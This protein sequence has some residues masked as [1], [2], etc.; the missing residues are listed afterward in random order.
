MDKDITIYDIAKGVGVSPTTVS[1][2]LNDHPAVNKKT[3]QRIYEIATQMGYRSN[4]FASN[5]RK[6]RTNTIGVIVPHLNSSFQSSVM[7]GMEKVATE[8]GYNL[9]ISQSMGTAEKEIANAKTMFNSRV[10]GLLV[11]LATDTENIDHFEPFFKKGVPVLFYDRVAEHKQS[12][13]I[14]IDNV[15]A[16][17]RATTHLIEQGCQRIVHITGNLRIN[18]YAHRLK[19]YKYALIDHDLPFN[20]SL[21]IVNDL[22]EEAGIEAAS[23]ILAMEPRPDGVFVSNDFCAANCMNALKQAGLS[24]PGDIAI[25]GFNNEPITRVV[26]P[27]LTTIDYPGYE[28]GEVAVRSLINYLDGLSDISITNTVTL[29]S[30]LI[31][32]G[33]SLRKPQV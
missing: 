26:E 17:Y 7:A 25:V 33:S 1:R 9:I 30:E 27:A 10:D 4:M 15:Q 32:R 19:G 21:V 29:R 3:K 23:Q 12:T 5:L 20:E 8:A 6:Q 14:I 13:S 22:T 31:V 11:S 2:A 16:A 24:I 18:V 28:M